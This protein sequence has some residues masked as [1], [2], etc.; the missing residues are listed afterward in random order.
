VARFVYIDET[1][2][3]GT[4]GRRQPYLTLVAAIVDESNVQLLS[5][6]LRKV[7]EAH[8]DWPVSNDLEFHGHEIWQGLGYWAGKSYDQLIAVYE[9]AMALVEA[10]EIDIAW[11]SID[12]AKLSARYGG[13][14]DENA[15]QLA[16]QFLLE[17][18]DANLGS[19]LKVLVA[20]EMKEQQL[21][22]VKMVADLQVWA[23][24]GVV[25]GRKLKTVIDSLH[26]VSSHASPGV[27]MADLIAFVIQRRR[28]PEKHPNAQAAMDRL[29]TIVN[30]HARTWREPL[31]A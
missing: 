5:D 13:A 17:K 22:A 6:G 10:C 26:F 30:D 16:L 9:E 1:G 3:V 24:G 27:Q 28:N 20:D 18:I 12:K 19:S 2:S 11:A 31:P 7:A 29:V 23:Y 15:Y 8:L 21:R 14:A 25:P 4:G